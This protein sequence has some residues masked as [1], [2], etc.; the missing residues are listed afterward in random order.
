M[1]DPSDESPALPVAVRKRV[2]AIA[3]DT[4]G[5]LPADEVPA[6]LRQVA[7]FTPT[8]RAKAGEAAL[9]TALAGRTFA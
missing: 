5:R 4:L 6:A 3:A 2:V 9:A 7:R 8:R 1:T